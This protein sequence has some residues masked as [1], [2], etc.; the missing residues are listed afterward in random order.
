MFSRFYGGFR[1]ERSC[2]YQISQ[3]VAA[4][5]DGFHQRLMQCSV[6]TLLEFSKAYDTVWREKLLLHM[7]NIGISLIFIRWIR[8][9][10]NYFRGRV[11]YFNVFSFSQFVTQDIPQVFV[12][13]PLTLLFY[14]NDLASTLNDDAVITLFPDDVSILTTAAKKEDAVAAVQ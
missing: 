11:Q 4:I 10:F 12:P 1:K 7:L 5:E 9:F 13:V 3:I 8:S 6:L 14:I 2:E